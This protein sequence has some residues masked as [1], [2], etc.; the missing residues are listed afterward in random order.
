[1]EDCARMHGHTT[2]SVNG[3][4]VETGGS[5]GLEY[6]IDQGVA[7]LVKKSGADLGN[8]SV[9]THVFVNEFINVG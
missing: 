9:W 5:L 4:P 6:Y 3:K 2:A 7:P 1:M 8:N